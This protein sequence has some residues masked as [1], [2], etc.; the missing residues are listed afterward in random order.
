MDR[1]GEIDFLIIKIAFV[2]LVLLPY[3]SNFRNNC[4]S[5]DDVEEDEFKKMK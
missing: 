1:E 2:M 3:Q 5:V 4:S